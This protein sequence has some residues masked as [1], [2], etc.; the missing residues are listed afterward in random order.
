[1]NE[2][3]VKGRIVSNTGPII[4]LM[5]ISK[6]G[7]LRELFDE[8]VIP[9]EVH[10]ELLQGKSVENFMNLMRITIYEQEKWIKIQDLQTSLNP[11]LKGMLDIG[12]ASVIQLASDIK[13]DFVLI[14]ERKARKIA[15]S[16]YGLKVVG[17]AR[18]LV[19]A[20]KRGLIQTVKDLLDEMRAGGYWIGD[21]IVQQIL[22]E[23]GE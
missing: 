23:A 13:P 11:A 18:I 19:E 3:T 1:M 16:M 12:E 15:R 9:H 6:L 4:A 17:T 14:D 22:K 21:T 8:V 10:Q 2:S 7:I 5:I 20:K